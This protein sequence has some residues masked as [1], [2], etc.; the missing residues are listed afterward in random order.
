M[1]YIVVG[2]SDEEHYDSDEM[3]WDGDDLFETQ[4]EAEIAARSWLAGQPADARVEIVELSD[5]GSRGLVRRILTQ[6][7]Y[8]DILYP[9]NADPW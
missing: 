2:F 7:G 1:T 9:G 6:A 8:E 3:A 5:D 4:E